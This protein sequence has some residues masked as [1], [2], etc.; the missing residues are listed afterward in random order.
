M[1]DVALQNAVARA[2]EIER[3]IAQR[4][5][6]IE[7]LRQSVEDAREHLEKTRNFI[8]TWY[9]MAGIQPPQSAER[10]ESTATQAPTRR[11][12]NPDREFVVDKSLELIREAGKPMPRKEL[13]DA[14]AGR[15]VII[16]GKDPEMV[17]ST[18]LWRSQDRI[19]RLPGHGYWPKD[20][21]FA[22]AVYY[23]ELDDILGAADQEPEDGVIADE[24]GDELPLA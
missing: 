1:T 21:E 19:V 13:F 16:R 3:Y 23:P 20:A 12:K 14:L 6:E 5:E 24:E 15:G 9:E 22:D 10:V 11:P 17:L 2:A 7:D 4:T 18:M 8:L